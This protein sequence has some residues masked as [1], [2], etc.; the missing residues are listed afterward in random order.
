MKPINR[1]PAPS[2]PWRR[3]RAAQAL[4]KLEGAKV[5]QAVQAEVARRLA[6]SRLQTQVIAKCASAL[7]ALAQQQRYG[8]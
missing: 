6:Q 5:Q 2:Y 3:R 1:S 4:Q 8:K 7:Q